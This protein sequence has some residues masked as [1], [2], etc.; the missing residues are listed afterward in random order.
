MLGLPGL[1][2]HSKDFATA[3]LS[4]QDTF[5]MS[6]RGMLCRNN[7]VCFSEEV[8]RISF[9]SEVMEGF[10]VVSVFYLSALPKSLALSPC[11]E[12]NNHLNPQG[13]WLERND[14]VTHHQAPPASP[15]AMRFTQLMIGAGGLLNKGQQ[16][17]LMGCWEPLVKRPSC[18]SREAQKLPPAAQVR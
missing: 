2:W 15:R 5:F 7:E 14:E 13:A 3:L 12:T 4:W 6:L 17:A 16:A 10:H 18:P 11:Q 9:G 8:Q 1:G